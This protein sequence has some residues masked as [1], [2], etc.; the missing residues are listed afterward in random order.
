MEPPI[1]APVPVADLIAQRLPGGPDVDDGCLARSEVAR[2]WPVVWDHPAVL[3]ANGVR[4]RTHHATGTY[5]TTTW[6]DYDAQDVQRVADAIADG[7][8][9]LEPRWRRDT[10]EG[11][12]ALRQAQRMW[13][14]QEIRGRWNLAAVALL[15]LAVVITLVLLT[16]YG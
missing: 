3:R 11:R 10:D 2:A 8:A 9:V 12:E 6:D 14:R 5:G 4:T 15:V 7:T 1:P 13:R 16:I